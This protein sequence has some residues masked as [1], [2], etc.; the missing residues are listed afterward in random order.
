MKMNA[1]DQLFPFEYV[2]MYVCMYVR[3][4]VQGSMSIIKASDSPL[5]VDKVIS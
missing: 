3:R 5:T 4:S 2:C 1:C